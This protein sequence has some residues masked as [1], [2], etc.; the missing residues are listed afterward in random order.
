[1]AII[2]AIVQWSA[3]ALLFGWKTRTD[4]ARE[5]V[6]AALFVVIAVALVVRVGLHLS[7]LSVEIDGP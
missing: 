4:P 6:W 1:V 3:A 2:L 5:R 7:G